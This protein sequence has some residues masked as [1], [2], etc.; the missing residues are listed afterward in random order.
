MS[1]LVSAVLSRHTKVEGFEIGAYSAKSKLYDIQGGMHMFYSQP[2][3]K[4]QNPIFFSPSDNDIICTMGQENLKRNLCSETKMSLEYVTCF[5]RRTPFKDHRFSCSSYL[6]PDVH[7]EPDNPSDCRVRILD[8]EYEFVKTCMMMDFYVANNTPKVVYVDPSDYSSKMFFLLRPIFTRGPNGVPVQTKS[9]FEYDSKSKNAVP[10]DVSTEVDKRIAGPDMPSSFISRNSTMTKGITIGNVID[11]LKNDA[12]KSKE[13]KVRV[14]V[15]LYY[16]N[17]V[18]EISVN[19]S[20][21]N[22][23]TLFVKYDASNINFRLTSSIGIFVR[24]D[25]VIVMTSKGRYEIPRSNGMSVITFSTTVLL[26]YSQMFDGNVILKR[27]QDQPMFTL[28]TN[29]KNQ[30]AT[31]PF[32]PSKDVYPYTN[33]C[34]PNFADLALRS[35][36]VRP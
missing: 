4:L 9:L 12:I 16:L 22:V 10:V 27:F 15:V 30:L 33:S 3:L 19:T 18:R 17:F 20:Q 2:N 1:L 21:T 11:S 7:F 25:R 29:A 26:M 28:S 35:N 31:G 32:A 8:G 5:D 23:C 24:S 6:S 36:V 13:M 34:I 14:P